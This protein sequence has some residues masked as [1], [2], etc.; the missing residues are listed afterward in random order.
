MDDPRYLAV[1]NQV[2]WITLTSL[3][4]QAQLPV[5]LDLIPIATGLC[6]FFWVKGHLSIC[7]SKIFKSVENFEH[8]QVINS[9]FEFFPNFFNLWNGLLL[10]S[11]LLGQWSI[12][13]FP[14]LNNNAFQELWRWGWNVCV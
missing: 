14:R 10:G 11:A 6:I 8:L 13:R 9:A 2:G 7:P 4:Q 1:P 3:L 5:T 12:K